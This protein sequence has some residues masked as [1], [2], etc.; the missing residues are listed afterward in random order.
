[1]YYFVRKYNIYI[2][3]N[4]FKKL[5]LTRDHAFY[6]LI[7]IAAGEDGS[8]KIWSRSGMLRSTLVKANFPILTSCW[9]PDCSVILY[10]QGANLLLQPLNSNSKPHKVR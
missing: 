1:M 4:I 10:S 9:S 8:V 2:N 3:I 5:F 6:V 7:L